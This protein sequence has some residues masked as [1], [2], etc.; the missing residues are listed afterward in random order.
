M[1]TKYKKKKKKKI[2]TNLIFIKFEAI[3]FILLKF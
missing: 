3:Y 1:T 2:Q